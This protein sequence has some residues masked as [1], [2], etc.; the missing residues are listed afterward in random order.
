[1]RI[2]KLTTS[3]PN[4]AQHGAP[5]REDRG[6]GLGSIREGGEL[7]FKLFHLGCE[8][9]GQFAEGLEVFE[10]GALF[11]DAGFESGGLG[12]CGG[13]GVDGAGDGGGAGGGVEGISWVVRHCEE[14]LLLLPE[15]GGDGTGMGS[16]WW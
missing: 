13:S 6:D 11:G 10:F 8:V 4:S 3:H 2:K 15:R 7:G 12:G 14:L 5:V 9:A 16:L 1:M